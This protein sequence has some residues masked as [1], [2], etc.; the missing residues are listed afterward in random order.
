MPPCLVRVPGYRIEP[1]SCVAGV[2]SR[3][4][5]PWWCGRR[6]PNYKC[7]SHAERVIVIGSFRFKHKD[8]LEPHLWSGRTA[9]RRTGGFPNCENPLSRHLPSR[10]QVNY[11]PDFWEVFFTVA[12][13]FTYASPLVGNRRVASILISV[14][15][16]AWFGPRRPKTSPSSI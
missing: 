5:F 14:V 15:L 11:P 1:V 9:A 2:G 8:G 6:T 4:L 16:P 13:P 3:H 7:K 10:Y 12:S